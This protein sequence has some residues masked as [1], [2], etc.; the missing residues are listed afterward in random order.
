MKFSNKKN[1][2]LLYILIHLSKDTDIKEKIHMINVGIKSV[3]NNN[4]IG[5]LYFIYLKMKADRGN[6]IFVNF[7]S[8][9]T[10]PIIE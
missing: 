7:H 5:K 3:L 10:M 4:K 6:C 8:Y 2:K 1:S 9:E